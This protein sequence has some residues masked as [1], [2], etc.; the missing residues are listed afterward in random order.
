MRWAGHIAGMG[1]R[2]GV[3]RVWWGRPWRR[4]EDNIKMELQEVR[5]TGIEWIELAQDRNRWQEL[6][7]P[8]MNLQI[9]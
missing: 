8:V 2:K 6:V 9:P 7:N 5:C 1:E 4:W 3:Y